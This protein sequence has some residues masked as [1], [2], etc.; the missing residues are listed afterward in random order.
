MS[1]DPVTLTR[2]EAEKSAFLAHHLSVD[3]AVVFVN[4]VARLWP[5][6]VRI[7]PDPIP[8]PGPEVAHVSLS[9]PGTWDR[10]FFRNSDDIPFIDGNSTYARPWNWPNIQQLLTDGWT[11]T[12]YVA[13][14]GAE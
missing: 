3:A 1:T 7:V 14:D 6:G 11:L 12:E 10:W 13:K 8:E 2:S 5:N 9:N 4:R